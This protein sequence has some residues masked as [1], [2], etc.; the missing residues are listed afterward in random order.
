MLHRKA[1][2]LKSSS[3]AF[4]HR[5]VLLYALLAGV[6]AAYCSSGA[7]AVRPDIS[8]EEN[9][10]LIDRALDSVFGEV[11]EA[12]GQ[13]GPVYYVHSENNTPAQQ[14]VNNKFP[15][16]LMKGGREVYQAGSGFLNQL[17]AADKDGAAISLTVGRIEVMYAPAQKNAGDEKLS[18]RITVQVFCKAVDCRNGRVLAARDVGTTLQDLIA[19]EDIA[20]IERSELPFT[21]GVLEQNKSRL[22]EMFEL[23]SILT[24]AGII[25]YLLFAT[26]S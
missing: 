14:Y 1:D 13:T 11:E 8:A 16:Y 20:Q 24:T 21:S 9:L 17:P 3:R 12:A 18:R 10:V 15:A 4:L 23:G 5:A 26:R 2:T 22:R 6:G 25:I 7:S 19:H